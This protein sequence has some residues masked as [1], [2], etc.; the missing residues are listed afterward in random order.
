M[1]DNNLTRDEAQRRAHLLRVDSY[2]VSLDLTTGDRTFRS[3]T[4]VTFRCSEPGATTFVEL[5]ASSVFSMELNG[6]VLPA[7]AF[8]GGRIALP[9]LGAD[10]ELRVVADCP[11]VNTGEGLHRFVDPVDS[12]VYLYSQFETYDAHRVYACFDQ[13]DLKSVF[14]FDVVAPAHWQVV[15]NMAAPEPSVS[16]GKRHWTF[17]TSP[18]MSTYYTAVVA[19]P[20]HVV[21][22]KHGDID[23]GLFCRK[24]LAQHLDP[25]E[26]LTVTKQG[27]DYFNE[28]FDY[29]YAFGKYDQ[30]FVPEFNAGAMENAGA[31][32]FLEDYV[33]RSKVTNFAYE[34]RAETILHEM[35]HMWFGDL[36]TMRWWDDLWLN[37]S[38]ATYAS[39]LAQSEATRFPHAWTTF[40]NVEK[41]WAYRQDQLPSTHPIVAEILDIAAVEVNFDGITYAKGASVLKQ[42]VAWVGRDAFRDG[43]RGY[44]RQHEY[45][46]TELRDLLRALEAASGRDLSAWSKEWLETAGVNTLRPSFSVDD[47]GNFIAFHVLQEAPADWPT[48]RSHRVAIGLYDV[49]GD[50]LE[51]RR[52]IELDVIGAETEVPQLIGERQPDLVLINDDDLTYTKIR[53]DPRSAA[54]VTNRLGELPGSLQRALCWAASWDMTRDAELPARQF[55]RLVLGN[56]GSESEVG[57]VQGLLGQAMSAIN[58]FADPTHREAP[59]RSVAEAAHEAMHAAEPGSDHQLAW[60]RAFVGAAHDDDHVAVVT[61]LRS[62]E[63]SLPGLTIDIDLRWSLVR[64]LAAL[65]R[66]TDADIEAEL[67]RDPT[68]AGQRQAATTRALRPT[69]EAKAEAWRN[70]MDQPDLPNAMLS[71]WISGFLHHDQLQLLEPYR[72]RYFER[73]TDIWS[74]RSGELAQD[75]V[76]GM[77]PGVFVDQQTLDLTDD[78]LRTASPP[79]PLRRL[80]IESRDGVARA[81]RARAKDIAAGSE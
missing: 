73:V 12:E 68:A 60:T 38:F 57:V 19:G 41:T 27:F 46:N 42:L 13:P 81:M 74:S 31:V 33:F 76:L 4:T 24:S 63:Y 66:L 28:T 80:L 71:A 59:L 5:I 22:D 36:V 54:T 8:D 70:I 78:Y 67:E 79:A 34:R 3:A 56:I 10:N 26:I 18:R 55:T 7:G 15:S 25:D 37:E 35:A 39:V 47:D 29:P 40:A 23:L 48:L 51:R 52:R 16:E 21:R 2:R 44:F 14:T 1:L 20:Y 62:G 6:E 53:L 45:A 69:G 77:Y 9:S 58:N 65:G 11:Y 72:K 30:L 49:S 75:I 61:A 50:G 43:L 17:A 64:A 32:T